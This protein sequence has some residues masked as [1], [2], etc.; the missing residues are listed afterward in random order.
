M[1]GVSYRGRVLLEVNMSIGKPPTHKYEEIK[2]VDLN[3]LAVSNEYFR[4]LI[5]RQCM[6]LALYVMVI[7]IHL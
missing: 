1:E 4:Y 7:H 6:L 2:I 3:K 5:V